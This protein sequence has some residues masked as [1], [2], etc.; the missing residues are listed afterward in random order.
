MADFFE[1]IDEL[2]DLVGHGDLVGDVT[3]DQI[4]AFNQHE[5]Y[6]ETG[7]N[8]GKTLNNGGHLQ[9][10]GGPLREKTDSYCQEIADRLLDEGP[11]KPM[12]DNMKNLV[13][14]VLIHAPVRYDNLRRSA[15]GT[16][17]D[18]GS[19]AWHQPAE[20]PRQSAEEL[21]AERA[22]RGKSGRWNPSTD[23]IRRGRGAK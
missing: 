19:V 13:T 8:A 12:I 16:V 11:V 3:V 5:G 6:W 18:E 21:K 20:V 17:T 14:Q 10:L 2:K 15:A 1:R 23:E 4:Y 22:G 9:Y 7:P